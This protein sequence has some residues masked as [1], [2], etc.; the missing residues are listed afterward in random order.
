[1]NLRFRVPE[2]EDITTYLKALYGEQEI[3]DSVKI[4]KDTIEKEIKKVNGDP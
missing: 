4:V 2:Q 3:K 1:M